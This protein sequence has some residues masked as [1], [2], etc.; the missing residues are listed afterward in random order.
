MGVSMRPIPCRDWLINPLRPSSGTHEIMRI[1]LEVQNGTVHRM[2]SAVCMPDER[3]W[4]ARKYATAKPSTSV[5]PQ[6]SRLNFS[7]DK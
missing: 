4:K 1:T 5:M 6:T 3:T 7:V 2:N